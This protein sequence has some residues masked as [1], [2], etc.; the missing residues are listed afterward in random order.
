MKYLVKFTNH[1]VNIKPY[2]EY[3]DKRVNELF[4]NHL[5]NIKQ[6]KKETILV[7]FYYLQTT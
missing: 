2:D 7:S 1:L 6:N 4:T 3:L 5:V